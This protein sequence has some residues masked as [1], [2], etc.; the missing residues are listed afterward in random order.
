MLDLVTMLLGTFSGYILLYGVCWG[1]DKYDIK[2]SK[3]KV[4]LNKYTNM[5]FFLWNRSEKVYWLVY[6]IIISESL[7]F[8]LLWI[9]Y[10]FKVVYAYKILSLLYVRV[11]LLGVVILLIRSVI[12]GIWNFI[13]RKMR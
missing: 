10:I 13:S 5:L 1:V 2:E 6:I 7:V 12:E 9:S 3:K 11:Y 4:R 8:I